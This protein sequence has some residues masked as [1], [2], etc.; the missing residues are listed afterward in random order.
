MRSPPFLSST[1]NEAP[2]VKEMGETS[3]SVSE[4]VL[5]TVEE[6]VRRDQVRGE[7][8]AENREC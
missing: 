6:E 7:R 5:G 1:S 8:Q 2:G 3:P 4:L